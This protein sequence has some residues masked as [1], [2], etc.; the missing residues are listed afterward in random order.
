ME[1]QNSS[2][3]Q[4]PGVAVQPRKIAQLR[5]PLDSD[6]A[7]DSNKACARND[8]RHHIKQSLQQ[9]ALLGKMT[10]TCGITWKNDCSKRLNFKQAACGKC[11]VC[12]SSFSRPG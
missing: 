7:L 3:T 10:A 6:Y 9:A 4:T 11:G 8:K 12:L 5:H 2:P 1:Q